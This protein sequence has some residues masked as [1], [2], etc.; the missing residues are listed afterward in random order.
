[1]ADRDPRLA[2]I[3]LSYVT[4]RAERTRSHSSRARVTQ[5]ELRREHKP[6]RRFDT[7]NWPERLRRVRSSISFDRAALKTREARQGRPRDTA[8]R[9]EQ[10]RITDAAWSQMDIDQRCRACKKVSQRCYSSRALAGPRGC[11]DSTPSPLPRCLGFSSPNAIMPA[12]CRPAG[13]QPLIRKASGGV[14]P[15]PLAILPPGAL[16]MHGHRRRSASGQDRFGPSAVRRVPQV[17]FF[18][19][20][21]SGTDGASP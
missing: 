17:C 21:Y 8:H 19:L 11:P 10:S 9:V 18:P 7:F 4:P 5:S 13:S 20:L 12:D 14:K 6:I 15:G 3:S 2:S 1:M 16:P